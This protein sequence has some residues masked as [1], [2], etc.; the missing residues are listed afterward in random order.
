MK[1]EEQ[2]QPGAAG[3][4]RERRE[5]GPDPAATAPSPK[6]GSVVSRRLQVQG[7]GCPTVSRTPVVHHGGEIPGE[8]CRARGTGGG[9]MGVGPRLSKP[10]PPA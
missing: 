7:G 5:R 2:V 9:R 1:E 3:R 10:C 4:A 8:L 6:W